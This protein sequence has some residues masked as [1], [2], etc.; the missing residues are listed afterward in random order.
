MALFQDLKSTHGEGELLHSVSLRLLPPLR[1]SCYI[2]TLLL[3]CEQGCGNM[4][5]LRAGKAG[6]AGG[7]GVSKP[8]NKKKGKVTVDGKGTAPQQA[9]L[10]LSPSPPTVSATELSILS[11][12]RAKRRKEHLRKITVVAPFLFSRAVAYNTFALFDHHLFLKRQVFQ[13]SIHEQSNVY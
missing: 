10:S 3:Y 4:S 8:R 6:S 11:S 9:F 7:E 5:L 1:P 13:Q 2:H 12:P